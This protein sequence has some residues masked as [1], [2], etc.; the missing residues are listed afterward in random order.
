M[1][2]AQKLDANLPAAPGDVF[3]TF[4]FHQ[5]NSAANSEYK[6]FT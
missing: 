2:W 1:I 5:I 3:K 4:Y 6:D